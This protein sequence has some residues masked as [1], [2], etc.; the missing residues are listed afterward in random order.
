VR[1]FS[2]CLVEMPADPVI[3]AAAELLRDGKASNPDFH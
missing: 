3:A 2:R 1:S